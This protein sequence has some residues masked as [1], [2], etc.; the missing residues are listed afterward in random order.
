MSVGR[1]CGS[2][3][4]GGEI[5]RCG[6]GSWSFLITTFASVLNQGILGDRFASLWPL[7]GRALVGQMSIV[8]GAIPLFLGWFQWSLCCRLEGRVLNSL[9]VVTGTG[10]LT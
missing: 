9:T 10:K 8:L 2:L 7:H 5:R 3:L 4:G 1:I 6:V